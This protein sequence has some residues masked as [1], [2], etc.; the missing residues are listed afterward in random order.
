MQITITKNTAEALS[1][2]W[3][4]YYFGM[5]KPIRRDIEEEYRLRDALKELSEA[6]EEASI[7]HNKEKKQ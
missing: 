5:F 2:I 6:I 4:A 1:F 3:Q 7:N